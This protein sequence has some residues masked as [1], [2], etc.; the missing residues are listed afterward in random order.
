MTGRLCAAAG[1]LLSLIALINEPID[2]LPP[3]TPAGSLTL[4]ISGTPVSAA[5]FPLD[6]DGLMAPPTVGSGSA[7]LDCLTAGMTGASGPGL[8][9][10]AIRDAG[11]TL[12]PIPADSPASRDG[13]TT[14]IT[15]ACATGFAGRSTD[16]ADPS[17]EGSGCVSRDRLIATGCS[18]KRDGFTR[19]ILIS[20][21]G[22]AWLVTRRSARSPPTER[23]PKISRG[24]ASFDGF[25][26]TWNGSLTA[27][28]RQNFLGFPFVVG[29]IHQAFGVFRIIRKRLEPFKP[30]WL[31]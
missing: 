10:D 18:D 11:S 24:W 13:R 9:V 5:G 4:A 12:P 28:F 15:A 20:A 29:R 16:L 2:S 23:P 21:G 6:P 31:G 27:M 8:W 7:S 19:T 1:F 17:S 25:T 26:C 14:G 3:R 30:E 22:A